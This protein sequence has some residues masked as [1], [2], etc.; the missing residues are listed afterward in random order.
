[1]CIQPRNLYK[2]SDKREKE[3]YQN[4]L[5]KVCFVVID[6]LHPRQIARM[7]LKMHKGKI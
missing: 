4:K 6:K 3:I 7:K 2:I 5:K 1:M